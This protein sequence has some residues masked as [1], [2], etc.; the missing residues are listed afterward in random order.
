MSVA[1]P[2][3]VVDG[4]VEVAVLI[5]TFNSAG[6]IESL[7]SSLR[8]EARTRSMRVVVA[9]NSSTD[10]TLDLARRH[11]D[12]ITVETQG[13]LGY[14]GGINV[15]SEHA[16]EARAHLILNPDLRM[17]PGSLAHLL[18]R[19]DADD[20]V[21]VVAPRI[22]DGD[23]TTA[24][25]LFHE[26]GILRAVGDALL[27]RLW[28]GRPAFLSEWDR[29]SGSYDHAHRTDWASGAALLVRRQAVEQIGEWDERFFLYSEETDYCRRARALG[30]VV[31]YEPAAIVEHVQGGSGRSHALDALQCVSRIRYMRKHAP[32]RAGLYRGIA[33]I[34]A[35]LRSRGSASQRECARILRDET[36]WTRLPHATWTGGDRLAASFVIPAHNE[37]SVIG[38][39]L[40][41]LAP[42]LA[43][44]SVEVTVVCNGCSD[45]TASL[46]RRDG[47]RVIELP[48]PSKIGALNA[49]DA[50]STAFPR[51]YLDADIAFPSAALPSLLRA[52][53]RPGVAAGRPRFEYDA[54][55]A[56]PLV[57]SY[58]RA[59]MRIPAMSGALW[60]A[61]VYAVGRSGHARVA[62]F[63]DV[64]ADDLYIDSAF[65]PFEKAFP[66]TPAARVTVPRTRRALLAVL[67]RARRGPA[68]Q[69]VDDGRS[70]AVALLRT[71][72][73]PVSLYDALV[74]AALTV[75]ARRRVATH[76]ASTGW[77][78]DETSRA[79]VADGIPA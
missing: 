79:P 43:A 68:E 5:V 2:R 20:D 58:Y 69:G 34:G 33:L 17:R 1:G 72:R 15:A 32:R 60:G 13:N 23:G 38:A 53:D 40:D 30:W 57:R 18:R 16:G 61:G 52:L 54:R 8:R 76:R 50:A 14:A 63:P 70:T 44:G 66:L 77:E 3:F 31:S 4:P 67:A 42:L 7:L 41:T 27:G 71:V 21:G 55:D 73:G 10:D 46:A 59:R 48:T 49:G 22:V 56:S 26:P 6:D 47:V 51:V 45:N 65:T 25:S 19:L 12:V 74:F 75:A 29:R 62:P 35:M 36:T 37:E 9:D 64:T 39:T 28:P 24:V 11:S 78:R